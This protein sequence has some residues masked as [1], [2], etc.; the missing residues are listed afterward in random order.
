[1]AAATAMAAAA[2]VATTAAVA[3]MRTPTSR[4]VSRERWRLLAR[5]QIARKIRHARVHTIE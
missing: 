5:A 3:A 1:M 2:A 4:L